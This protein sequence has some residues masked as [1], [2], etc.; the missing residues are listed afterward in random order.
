[1]SIFKSEYTLDINRGIIESKSLFEKYFQN[2]NQKGY[3]MSTIILNPDYGTKKFSGTVDENGVYN[4]RL[5]V[6]KETDEFYKSAPVNQ[7]QFLG[8]EMNTKV[9]V[10][11]GTVKSGVIF[12]A[13]LLIAVVILSCSILFINELPMFIS[14]VCASFV[15]ALLSLV[16]LFV[17]K[18]RINAAKETLLYILKYSDKDILGLNKSKRPAD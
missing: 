10:C 5:I 2:M 8:D 3:S 6:S 1:M 13:I 7:I 12:L 18:K 14:I 15:I 16:P 11:V 9:R 17:K 4:A